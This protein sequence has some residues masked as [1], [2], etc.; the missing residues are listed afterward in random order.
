[1]HKKILLKLT[2]LL[3]TLPAVAFHKTRVLIT[4]ARFFASAQH[5]HIVNTQRQVD[6]LIQK[7]IVAIKHHNIEAA[8]ALLKQNTI[9]MFTLHE[10]HSLAY[11]ALMTYNEDMITLLHTY[12]ARLLPEEKPIFKVWNRYYPRFFAYYPPEACNSY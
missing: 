9:N 7:L 5:L 12:G 1:M 10:G 3:Q 8:E 11:T 4:K 2:L 6:Q